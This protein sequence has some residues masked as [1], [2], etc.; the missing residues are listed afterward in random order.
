M[1]SVFTARF[2][3]AFSSANGRRLEKEKSPPTSSNR[4]ERVS[5]GA[6][7]SGALSAAYYWPIAHILSKCS[8]RWWVV[9]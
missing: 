5:G 7:N 9:T 2:M 1:E 3:L 4:T 6:G 8:S